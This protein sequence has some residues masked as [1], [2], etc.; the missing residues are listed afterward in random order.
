MTSEEQSTSRGSGT[1]KFMA[2]EILKEEKYNEKA[3]V[4][5]FGVILF[6]MISGG[7]MPKITIIQMG[8]GKKAPIPDTFT[9]FASD[10]INKC[11]ETDPDDRPSFQ[12]IAE[13]LEKN[14]YNLLELTSDDL[15]DLRQFIS[16]HK[17]R[18]PHY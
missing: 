6:F 13:S 2:P 16:Q 4:Y 15:E 14:D 18:I 5:S 17:K 3:D 8:N 10:L 9:E 11:W 12:E 1:Q 7:Q